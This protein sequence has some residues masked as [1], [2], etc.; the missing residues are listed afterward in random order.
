AITATDGTNTANLPVVAPAAG[1]WAAAR[2]ADINIAESS[3]IGWTIGAGETA[4]VQIEYLAPETKGDGGVLHR[5]RT[6]EVEA[7][8]DTL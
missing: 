3:Y 6:N 8:V 5:T 7:G 2:D 1:E 4:V